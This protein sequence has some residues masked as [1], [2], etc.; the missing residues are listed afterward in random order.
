ME[1]IGRICARRNLGG[2]MVL[3]GVEVS[4]RSLTTFKAGQYVHLEWIDPPVPEAAGE[5]RSLF[6]ASPPGE[7]PFLSFVTRTG[8]SPFMRCLERLKEGAPVRITGPFGS[9]T[10]PEGL[11]GPDW[12]SPIVLV[13]E[14]IGISAAR[15][16]VLDG[17]PRTP[18]T[19]FY[20]FSLARRQEV[21]PFR[22]EWMEVVRK[23]PR[24]RFE[25]IFLGPG[26]GEIPEAEEDPGDR[27][28]PRLFEVVGEREIRRAEFYLSGSLGVVESVRGA[29]LCA[30]IRSERIHAEACLGAD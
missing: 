17:I 19:L 24:F 1:T 25:E 6:V 20:L 22:S 2:N 29:L 27:I 3:F 14:G 16:L 10:L 28:L 30:G 15:S 11:G 26:E 9:F 13:P 23:H 12:L 7:L 5:G 18:T 8:D 21:L 4:P